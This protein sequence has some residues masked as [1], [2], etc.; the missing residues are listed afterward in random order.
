MA[1]F[2]AILAWGWLPLTPSHEELIAY[3]GKL[4]YLKEQVKLG[5][6]PGWWITGFLGGFSGVAVM[7]YVVSLIP[8]A[9]LSLVMPSVLAFKIGGLLMLGLGALAARSFGCRFS[10]CEWSGS[11]IGLI[12]LCSAQLLMRLGWQEHMTIVTAFPLIPLTFLTM[13]RVAE[14]GSPGDALLLAV[15]FS[16]TL[17]CWS[18]I[19]ATL[20]VPLAAFALWI[21]ISRPETRQNLMRGACWSVPGILLMGVLPLLP[22]IREFG[23]MTVFELRPFADWQAMYS[24]KSAASWFD[25]GGDLFKSLPTVL[26]VDRG[27]YYLGLLQILS[28]AAI[29]IRTWQRPADIPHGL[30]LSLALTLGMFWLSVG[31][32]SILQGHMEFMSG[33]Y[34]LPDWSVSLIWFGLIAPA[35]VFW[36]MLPHSRLRKVWFTGIAAIYYFVPGFLWIE[37]IPLFENLRAPDSFWILN[38]TFAW[39]VASGIALVSCLRWIQFPKWRP[40]AAVGACAFIIW[41]ASASA[42]G[43]FASGLSETLYS[44]FGKAMEFLRSDPMPGRVLPVSGRYFYLGTPILAERPLSTEAAHHNF[45]LRE[46][47]NL[48]SMQSQSFQTL[49][50][51][52]SLAGVS[53]ILID[54]KDPGLAPETSQWFNTWLSTVFENEHFKI[55]RNPDALFPAFLST[56]VERMPD[57]IASDALITAENGILLLNDTSVEVSKSIPRSDTDIT[58]FQRVSL[59]KNSSNQ[60]ELI[61]N[62]QSGVIVLNQAWHPDWTVSVDGHPRNLERAAGAFPAVAVNESDTLVVF[63]FSPPVWYQ[64]TILGGITSWIIVLL[65]LLA[66]C[67]NSRVAKIFSD[68]STAA[69]GLGEIKP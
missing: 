10:R 51:Y 43:F 68:R 56:K 58:S 4:D 66:A 49:Q 42:R 5:Q 61:M 17:L 30:R 24:I 35:I 9:L 7:S 59:N 8:Y 20:S 37:K 53:H 14:R 47:A 60:F 16:A 41:D 45:M 34:Q 19:G 2:L 50:T 22:L 32:R 3:A 18:K 40:I 13:L 63:L 25:R 67:F 6:F 69:H 1:A 54:K 64:I 46:T 57:A 23:F 31:P 36:W 15:S 55:L 65:T 62:N 28:V 27:G 21:F 29:L 11:M 48:E 33:A 52:L 39:S 26:Q 38:G 12:Y 44:D